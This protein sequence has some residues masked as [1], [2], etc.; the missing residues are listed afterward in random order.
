MQD[1]EEVGSR[2]LPNASSTEELCERFLSLYE[3]QVKL[4]RDVSC[5][6]ASCPA[7]MWALRHHYVIQGDSLLRWSR[8]TLAQFQSGF[9]QIKLQTSP[10]RSELSSEEREAS[11]LWKQLQEG[12]IL[13]SSTQLSSKFEETVRDKMEGEV[14]TNITA[15]EKEGGGGESGLEERKITE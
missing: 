4:C 11:N 7:S 13:L 10:T 14:C 1:T 9:N 3:E 2:A 8:D 6:Y 5:I 12:N 15:G